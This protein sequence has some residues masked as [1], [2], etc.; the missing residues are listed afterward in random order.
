MTRAICA[1]TTLLVSAAALFAQDTPQAD[2]AIS[3]SHLQVLKGYTI[4]MNGGGGSIACNLT[5]WFGLAADIGMYHGYPAQSLTG[6]TFTFGPRFTYRHFDR[7]QPFAQSFFGGSHFNA[8]S[9]GI[10]GGGLPLAFDFG[11]GADLSLRRHPKLGVRLAD[12]FLGTRSGGANTISNRL[13]VRIVFRFGQ[14]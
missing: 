9:G 3:Y 6:E 4:S 1:M 11:F 2:L 10:T 13:S 8:S 12:D 5:R 7:F 14:K